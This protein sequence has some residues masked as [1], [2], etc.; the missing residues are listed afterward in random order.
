VWRFVF[1][2]LLVSASLDAGW[3]LFRVGS[4]DL[5]TDA[6]EK[7]ARDALT[8]L[9]QVRHLCARL[10][11]KPEVEPRWP[12]RILLFKPG[13]QAVAQATPELALS[14]DA[15]RGAWPAN[16]PLPAA[17]IE[18][19][20]RE[21]WQSSTP[22]MEPAYEAGLLALFSTLDAKATRISIG[23]P[24]PP[25]SR[26]PEWALLHMIATN[27]ETQ[28]RMR[29]LISNLQ[30]MVG[31]DLA[32]KNAYDAEGA[33]LLA[34]RNAHLKS[35]RFTATEWPGAPISPER[36][37]RARE[38]DAARAGS[39]L[40]DPPNAE[41]AM[42]VYEASLRESN[43][44][45]AEKLL[46]KASELNPRW[47]EPHARIAAI[48]KDLGH[49]IG[50]M[51]KAVSLDP[52]RLEWWRQLADWQW[53]GRLYAEAQQSWRQAERLAA[54]PALKQQIAARGQELAQQRID[55]ETAD[56]L[57]AE[58]EKRA[59]LEKLRQEALARIRQAEKKA[60]AELNPAGTADAPVPWW[61]GPRPSGKVAGTLERMDC[62]KQGAKIHIREDTAKLTVLHIPDPSKIVLSGMGE[63]DMKCG[64]QKPPRR[65]I[66]EYSPKA[67][68]KLG[69]VGEAA[70]I[71]FA[72]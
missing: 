34:E 70:L 9:E 44:E 45:A 56:R 22:A 72:Q 25:D 39:F 68:A 29:I 6:D 7:Y 53:Q 1:L 51:K 52:R 4:I 57:R 36:D 3:T 26:T 43:A 47:A 64:P 55:L 42:D 35:A 24:P 10:A 37:F 65:V 14:R 23:A 58:E 54:D 32:M 67:D 31:I 11:G 13:R 18:A 21:L 62:L 61:D 48:T 19:W 69:T 8:R 41:V 5:V 33:K 38:Y 49:K 2:S 63:M 15:Y 59:E 27:P 71:E 28:G 17:W 66:I 30:Q 16:E 60:N 50:R 20:A 46:V 12:L 40:K